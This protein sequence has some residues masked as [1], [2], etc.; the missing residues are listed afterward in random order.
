[1]DDLQAQVTDEI[2][3]ITDFLEQRLGRRSRW[4]GDVELSEDA[5]NYGKALWSGSISINR[6]LAT[7]DLRWRTEIHEAL[8]LFSIGLTSPTYFELPGWEEGVVEQLQRTLRN[9]VLF[10]LGFNLASSIFAAVENNHKVNR[11]IEALEAFRTALGESSP[12]FYQSLLTTPVKNRPG[13]IIELGRLLPADDYYN[14][15]RIFAVAFSKLRG[16]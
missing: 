10:S 15:Q 4:N 9:E 13:R 3:A 2:A 8:H 5:D 14:F 11:Y 6:R 12:S 16:G 7:T 1:M